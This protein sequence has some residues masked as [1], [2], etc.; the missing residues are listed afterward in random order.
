M[1]ILRH[2]TRLELMRGYK[3]RVNKKDNTRTLP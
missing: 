1:L 3:L 2:L